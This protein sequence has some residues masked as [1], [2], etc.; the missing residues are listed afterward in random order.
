MNEWKKVKFGD[1]IDVLSGFAFK[2]KVFSDSGI[3]VIKIKNVCPPYIS[4]EDLSYVPNSIAFQNPRYILRKGDVLIAMTGSHINQIASVVGRVGRVR[5]DAITVLN[6]RV[7]KIVNKNEAKSSLDYIY[8]YLSQYEVKVELAQK[9]GG[10][11]NQA[12]ISPSDIKNLLI[13][14]PP[15]EI[16]HRIATILS[17]YDSLIENY[18]KQIKLLEESAQRLY[19]EWFIDLRFP[20]HEN[21]KIV[22]GVPE[23]WEKKKLV[24]MVDVQYGYAFDGKLF[25][26]NSEGM[27]ILRIRNIPDGIT[28]DYTTEEA[29]DCYIVHNGDIVVGMDGIFHINSWSGGDAYLVQRACSFRPKEEC[30]KGFIFQAIQEPIKFFEKTLVGATVAH[31]GKKHIDSIELC[32]PKNFE[33][34]KPFSKF[35]NQRQGLLSQIRLLTE[36]RD[37]LLPRLMNG[38]INV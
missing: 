25:N 7:G 31:L 28:S 36:A 16:Q 22:D 35:Y 21:T 38:V 15:I 29:Q 1:Y 14:Y 34:Y 13:P 3:P 33:L 32:I 4:L 23:G 12:N 27:P 10:A 37:R 26:S 8:Y 6:Q 30:M 5:Y 11:A 19:K 20:G 18:Q 2:S 9:A 24:D 17:R